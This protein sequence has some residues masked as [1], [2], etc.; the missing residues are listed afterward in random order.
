MECVYDVGKV[1]WDTICLRA[2]ELLPTRN[3]AFIFKFCRI[4]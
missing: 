3:C 1:H 2:V 4:T